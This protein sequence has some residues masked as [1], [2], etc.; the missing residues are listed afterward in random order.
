MDSLRG[1]VLVKGCRVEEGAKWFLCWSIV[2][3][4]FDI[5]FRLASYKQLMVE[6]F[7]YLVFLLVVVF[8]YYYRGLVVGALL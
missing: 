4:P 8:V 5:E 2:A 1:F 6:D 7:F 3:D